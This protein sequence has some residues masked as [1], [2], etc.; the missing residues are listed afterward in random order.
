MT[1]VG[2][3]SL[4]SR[5]FQREQ[6]NIFIFTVT[7]SFGVSLILARQT[8][9][10]TLQR[11]V[12]LHAMLVMWRD[13]DYTVCWYP[14]LCKK[15]P[16]YYTIRFNNVERE[17]YW[18]HVVR[19]SVRPSVCGQYRFR[20][21]TSTI[22]TGSISYSHILLSNFRRCVACNVFFFLQNSKIW[23]SGNFCKFVTLTLSCFDL[24]SDTDQ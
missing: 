10:Q 8:V 6:K 4:K 2:Y 5:D 22:L 24:G 23:F 17:V 13:W 20:S 3:S 14:S 7:R 21:V 18:F 11:P 19:P 12:I 9:E 15:G 16:I 1:A